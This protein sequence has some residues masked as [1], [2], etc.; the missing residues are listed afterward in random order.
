MWNL[1]VSFDDQ[2]KW[3][4]GIDSWRVGQVNAMRL[5]FAFAKTKVHFAIVP[6]IDEPEILMILISATYQKINADRPGLID[7]SNNS[8]Y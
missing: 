2:V 5:R 6:E 4:G 3:F 1:S 7:R 8:G